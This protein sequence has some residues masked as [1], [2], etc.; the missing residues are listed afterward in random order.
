MPARKRNAAASRIQAAFRRRRN[1]KRK[2]AASITAAQK[3]ALKKII[4][5]DI[6]VFDVA[7]AYTDLTTTM[8][9]QDSDTTSYNGAFFRMPKGTQDAARNNDSIKALNLDLRINVRFTSPH[10]QH[11][12]LMLVQFAV[13]DDVDI[14]EVLQTTAYSSTNPM[15]VFNSFKKRHPEIKYKILKDVKV[16]SNPMGAGASPSDTSVSRDK[17]IRIY[18]KFKDS[19]S[20][21]TYVTD[22]NAEP[23]TNVTYLWAC[24]AT[25]KTTAGG[26]FTNQ[27]APAISFIAR[28]RYM[29]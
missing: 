4:S 5:E 12:R 13:N 26:N 27:T 11:A 21:M 29:R 23:V 10:Q 17:N 2:P 3:S 25:G 6:S 8:S 14:A 20:P 15:N 22:N 19:E 9:R 16:T 1:R 7:K 24:Y 18:H 28:Q